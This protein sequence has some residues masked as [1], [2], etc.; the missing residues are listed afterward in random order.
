MKRNVILG[1]AILIGCTFGAYKLGK[2][3]GIVE[4]EIGAY[5]DCRDS[6][7]KIIDSVENVEYKCVEKEEA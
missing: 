5:N 7:L 1:W 6:L 2:K 3:V 4:G